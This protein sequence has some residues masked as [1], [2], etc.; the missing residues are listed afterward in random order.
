MGWWLQNL[1]KR[2][3]ILIYVGVANETKNPRDEK[4]LE[5]YIVGLGQLGQRPANNHVDFSLL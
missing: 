2:S 4:T 3:S 5:L 1:M